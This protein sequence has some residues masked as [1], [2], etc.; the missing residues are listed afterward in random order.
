M[1]LYGLTVLSRVGLG[2]FIEKTPAAT[3]VTPRSSDQNLGPCT[4]EGR[5]VRLEPLRQDHAAALFEVGRNLDWAWMLG[6]LRMKEA[7]DHR[8]ADGLKAE[9]RDASYTF[10][11]LL[12]KEPRVIG[13]TAIFR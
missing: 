13:S 5:F 2:R 8:I 1:F 6:P 10:A 3:G 9:E 11:V 12:K 7:V 4:L